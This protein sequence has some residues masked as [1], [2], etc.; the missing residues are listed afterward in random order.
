MVSLAC[1]REDER[2]H[3]ECLI[4]NAPLADP[5][6][7]KFL[8]RV[9][10]S[11]LGA[12]WVRSKQAN[13]SNELVFVSSHEERGVDPIRGPTP[14]SINDLRGEKRMTTQTKQPKFQ[15]STVCTREVQENLGRSIG[16]C[17]CSVYELFRLCFNE[18]TQ[19]RSALQTYPATEGAWFCSHRLFSAFPRA[20]SFDFRFFVVFEKSFI[21]DAKENVAW[22]V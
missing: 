20:G 19:N 4:R 7:L 13:H 22:G 12:P 2:T 15:T 11:R 14:I 1:S 9:D 5:S 3:F 21:F 6:S 8:E 16:S 18:I 10:P 17:I